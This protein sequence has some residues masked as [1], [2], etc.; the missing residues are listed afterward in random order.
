MIF[1]ELVASVVNQFKSFSVFDFID[2]VVIA[3]AIYKTLVYVKDTRA[4][5]LLKAIVLI[6]ILIDRKSTRLNSSH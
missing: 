1:G 6:V 4:W 5:Q 2:L 3:Y